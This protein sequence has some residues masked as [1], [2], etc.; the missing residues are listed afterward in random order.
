MS[1]F[2][3]PNSERRINLTSDIFKVD[4]I[5]G[6]NNNKRQVHPGDSISD[7]IYFTIKYTDLNSL[8][9]EDVRINKNVLPHKVTMHGK[10]SQ[11]L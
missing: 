9:F 8:P 2:E 1:Q 3:I 7:N 4:I 6:G 5:P 11:N 10:M